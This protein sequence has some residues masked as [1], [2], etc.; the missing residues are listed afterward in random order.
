MNSRIARC[1]VMKFPSLQSSVLNLRCGKLLPRSILSPLSTKHVFSYR[2]QDILELISLC[3]VLRE[4]RKQPEHKGTLLV[5]S[6][7]NQRGAS[8]KK[9]KNVQKL[10]SY[11]TVRLRYSGGIPFY[12]R[13]APT[14]T[15]RALNIC[16]FG[17][18]ECGVF[19][20][21]IVYTHNIVQYI[22]SV[23]EIFCYKNWILY[24]QTL[25]RITEKGM[26]F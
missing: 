9:K 8:Q 16:I 11:R 25:Y 17:N 1:F 15:L 20:Y 2:V 12:Q 21:I 24:S 14:T 19:I 10:I 22:L 26:P 23:Q 6:A 18:P 7:G 13:W 3:M 5:C 4:F